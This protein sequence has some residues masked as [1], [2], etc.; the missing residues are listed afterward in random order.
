MSKVKNAGSSLAAPRILAVLSDEGLTPEDALS[1][2]AVDVNV[3]P[4]SCSKDWL[5]LSVLVA[6]MALTHVTRGLLRHLRD[7]K[8][9]RSALAQGRFFYYL[10]DID[11]TL[12]FTSFGL[13]LSVSVVLWIAVTS[14]P[15]RRLNKANCYLVTVVVALVNSI[16]LCICH[17]FMLYAFVES[18][19]QPPPVRGAGK[20]FANYKTPKVAEENILFTLLSMIMDFVLYAFFVMTSIHFYARARSEDG[21]DIGFLKNV[22]RRTHK[23]LIITASDRMDETWATS[24]SSPDDSPGAFRWLSKHVQANMDSD[25]TTKRRRR[26]RTH[27][28]KKKKVAVV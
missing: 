10:I 11:I 5:I 13:I 14:S 1:E 27:R 28:K 7:K 18:A 22:L 3:S 2:Y 21:R 26:K 24:P 25:G 15:A 12:E 9:T 19:Q 17:S 8:M 23:I 16:L 20:Q 6:L 4:C